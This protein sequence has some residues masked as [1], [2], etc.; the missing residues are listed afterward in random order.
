M[1]WGEGLANMAA[2]ETAP[3]NRVGVESVRK[4]GSIEEEP[5]LSWLLQISNLEAEVSQLTSSVSHYQ[6]MATEYKAQLERQ[7]AEHEAFSK[8]LHL[9]EQE[10]DQL[11]RENLIE[12]EKVL[13]CF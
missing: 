4:V 10:I 13:Q 8:E 2:L 3:G 5:L 7:R 1:L 12:A 9:K 6:G 11:K